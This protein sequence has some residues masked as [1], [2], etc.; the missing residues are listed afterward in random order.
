M[1]YDYIVGVKLSSHHFRE[2]SYNREEGTTVSSRDKYSTLARHISEALADNF[3]VP[4][5]DE[6]L[7]ILSELENHTL[8]SDFNEI[9]E[10]NAQDCLE[11][12][13]ILG[14]EAFCFEREDAM[15]ASIDDIPAR[16]FVIDARNAYYRMTSAIAIGVTD[17]SEATLTNTVMEAIRSRVRFNANVE[18]VLNFDNEIRKWEALEEANSGFE[19]DSRDICEFL[20]GRGF[21]VRIMLS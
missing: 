17:T 8:A 7:Q 14:V 11:A 16:G 18:G 12:L 9:E 3:T 19:Y 4:N 10:M 1:Y 6:C 5:H 20:E 15:V 2:L 13:A 21:K